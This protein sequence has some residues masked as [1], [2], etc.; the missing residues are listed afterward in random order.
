MNFKN[1]S[2]KILRYYVKFE[3]IKYNTLNRLKFK[4][5]GQSIN[6]NNFI[7]S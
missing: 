7:Q 4:K 6:K 3:K 1:S 5:K 2:V